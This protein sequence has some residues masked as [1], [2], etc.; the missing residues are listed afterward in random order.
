VTGDCCTTPD[1]PA[2]QTCQANQ[3]AAGCVDGD[4]DGYGQ[5]SACQGADCDDGDAAV[6]PGATEDCGDGLDNDCDGQTDAAD[7]EVCGEEP[8]L[9]GSCGCGGGGTA[10]SPLS[11]ALGVGL[12]LFW[13]RR[14]RR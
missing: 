11:L 4:G 7:T 9:V 2:G 13:K 1:C 8:V 14:G 6:H 12:G 10:G 3:C 5:G